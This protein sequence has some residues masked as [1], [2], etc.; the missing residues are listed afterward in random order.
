[1]C[2]FSVCM[3]VQVCTLVHLLLRVLYGVHICVCV[4][5]CL[6]VYVTCSVCVCVHMCVSS[7]QFCFSDSSLLT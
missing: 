5:V 2:V 1:M 6:H 3:D 7:T 4:P